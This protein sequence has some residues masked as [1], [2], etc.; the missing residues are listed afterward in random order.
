MGEDDMS[1][2]A[3]NS[4]ASLSPR[5]QTQ[6]GTEWRGGAVAL[7]IGA[8]DGDATLDVVEFRV[9]ERRYA[10]ERA[11]VREV[12]RFSTM[13]PLPSRAAFLRG[14]INLRGYLVPVIDITVI[15]GAPSSTIAEARSALI[16]HGHDAELGILAD[17]IIGNRSVMLDSRQPQ[18]ADPAGAVFEYGK[19]AVDAAVTILDI[20][21]ILADPRMVINEVEEL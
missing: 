6:R 20:G 17:A 2:A 3:P 12:C 14:M 5:R 1:N 11:Y 9:G 13:T 4:P 19:G 15:L 10:V 7:P 8:P 16:V 21:R 18:P